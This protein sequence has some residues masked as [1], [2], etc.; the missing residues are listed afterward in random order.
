M[1]KVDKTIK[2]F[3]SMNDEEKKA[4]IDF[5]KEEEVEE[6]PKKE[7]KSEEKQEE[8]KKEEV[9]E[10][11]KEEKKENKVDLQ[12]FMDKLTEDFKVVVEEV[13]TLK[14]QKTAQ[15]GVKAK[16]KDT[17]GENSFDSVFAKLTQN[18]SR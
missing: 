6:E 17:K 3:A 8:P 18:Q 11:P 1:K 14:E 7:V 10:K 5:F 12:A 15:V 9:E 4:F 13:K 2:L 16:P